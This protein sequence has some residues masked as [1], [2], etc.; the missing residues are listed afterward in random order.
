MITKDF[1]DEFR[2]FADNEVHP[3]VSPDNWHIYSR[4]IDFIDEL[5]DSVKEQETIRARS[6]MNERERKIVTF[7]IID[8][9]SKVNRERI[10]KYGAVFENGHDFL[11]LMDNILKLLES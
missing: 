9:L 5:D 8:M 3:V 1:V 11:E 10:E 2:S 7:Q 6:K 4:L